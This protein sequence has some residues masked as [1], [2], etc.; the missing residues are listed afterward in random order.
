[1][2]ATWRPNWFSHIAVP[3]AAMLV[4][5][6]LLPLAVVIAASNR[7]LAAEVAAGRFRADLFYRLNVVSIMLVRAWA[8]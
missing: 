1:M 3:Y 6:T 7:D 2:R 8:D 5:V 4:A